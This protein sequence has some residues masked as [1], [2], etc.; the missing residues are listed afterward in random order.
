M[1]SEYDL[2]FSALHMEFL[3]QTSLCLVAA[4]HTRQEDLVIDRMKMLPVVLL[5]DYCL[6][7]N[8]AR[9]PSLRSQVKTEF[10]LA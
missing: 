9:D 4:V 7:A 6:W 1:Y 3:R 10:L 5:D 2:R 8:S